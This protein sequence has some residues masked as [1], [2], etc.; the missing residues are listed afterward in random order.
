MDAR[1]RCKLAARLFAQY[2]PTTAGSGGRSPS[3]AELLT[4][5][6]ISG[7][8]G[9]WGSWHW[10]YGSIQCTKSQHAAGFGPGFSCLPLQDR[11]ADGTEYTWTYRAYE[12]P[13]IAAQ[14]FLR[15]LYRRPGVAAA[16]AGS[17]SPADVAAAM[18]A[19]GYFE[20]A[21]S[22]YASAITRNAKIAEGYVGAELEQL[23]RGG[24][25]GSVAGLLILGGL[26]AAAIVGAY[27]FSEAS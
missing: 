5:L 20:A 13:E 3:R 1:E 16:L 21:A 24:G 14:D 17:A 10:N 2:L 27:Y 26:A 23:A 4:L 8:E 9:T 7:L 18:R 12:S 22:T 19:S 15:E 6:G 25:G 11:H